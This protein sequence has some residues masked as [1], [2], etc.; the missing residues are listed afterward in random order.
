MQIFAGTYANSGGGGIYPLSYADGDWILGKPYKGARNASYGAYSQ[1][2]E[3]HYL[4]DE[5]HSGA[6]GTYRLDADGWEPLARSPTRGSEPCF[7]SLDPAEDWL[8]VAN[9]GSGSLALL[10]IDPDT[11]LIGGPDALRQ[12]RGNGPDRDR[13]EGPHAH[14]AVFGPDARWLYQTDLGADE[15][16]AFPFDAERGLLGDARVAFRAPAGSGP[17]H[18][19]FHPS[20]PLVVLLSELAATIT[21]LDAGI[22][23]VLHERQSLPTTGRESGEDNLGG[24]IAFDAAGDRL[25]VTNRGHDSIALFAFDP[26]AGL[27]LVS[28]TPSGGASPRHFL[29]LE[30]QHK[31]LVACEKDDRITIFDVR[32]DGSLVQS[33]E[34]P[35]PGAAYIFSANPGA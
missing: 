34:V 13:Q 2:H 21:L 28:E 20:E 9:Y 31:L 1:R 15:L 8:A 14:C 22:G 26:K 25:Y 16:L 11:G 18:L 19:V 7:A 5:D 6:V 29:L 33:G 12:N 3:L 35:V 23:G 17:R 4:L 30:S 10:R 24:H 32:T 27:S